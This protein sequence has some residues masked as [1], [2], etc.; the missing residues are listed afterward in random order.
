[1]IKVISNNDHAPSSS[2]SVGIAYIDCLDFLILSVA[3]LVL[4]IIKDES[5]HVYQRFLLIHSSAYNSK[6]KASI[7]RLIVFL[8]YLLQSINNLNIIFSYGII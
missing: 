3:F 4:Y 6:K 1:M 5:F 2:N 8:K 7:S